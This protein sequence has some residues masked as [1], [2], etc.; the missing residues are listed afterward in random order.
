MICVTVLPETVGRIGEAAERALDK[1]CV[2]PVTVCAEV[3]QYVFVLSQM[4]K[5]HFD[6]VGLI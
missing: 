6:G 2:A 3:K 1:S 5:V 4:V